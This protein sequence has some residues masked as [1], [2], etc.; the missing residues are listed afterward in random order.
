MPIKKW[1]MNKQLLNEVL[2]FSFDGEFSEYGFS[3]RLAKENS[4]TKNFTEQ[5]ILEYKKFMYLAATANAMVSPSEIVDIVWHQ[6]LIFTQSYKEFCALLGKTIQHIPST[7]NRAEFEKFNQ[8]KERTRNLYEHSFGEQPTEIWESRSIYDT[9]GLKKGEVG[10][11]TTVW[12]GVLATL[13]LSIPAFFLLR[14][15]FAKI[16]NP[17]FLIIYSFAIVLILCLLELFNRDY[18]EKTINKIKKEA[19][20]FNLSPLELVFL[21]KEDLSYSIHGVVNELVEKNRFQVGGDYKLSKKRKVTK[22]DNLEEFQV[23]DTIEELGSTNYPTLLK[24]LVRKPVFVNIANSMDNFKSYFKETEALRSV[25]TMNFVILAI[26]FLAGLTRFSVGVSREKPVVFIGLILVVLLVIIT[27]YLYRLITFMGKKTL[28][29]WYKSKIGEEQ[30][31]KKDKQW[32][33][34]MLGADAF[35]LSFLPLT[36]Y[37]EKNGYL[38]ASNSCGSSCGSSCGGGCSGG[39][40]G[41]CGGC[42]G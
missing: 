25:F 2:A 14:P 12:V 24:H 20:I 13:F 19:F 4:W 5:A 28:P 30:K 11:K 33:Y 27:L 3:T 41:G 6:H 31:I 40:G 32:D 9:L 18:F 35:A 23:V 15:V 29:K 36:T 21:Q 22:A 39:C 10:I 8:A 26:V 34:F 17:D 7:H 1:R 16:G 42:G 38:A 37:T